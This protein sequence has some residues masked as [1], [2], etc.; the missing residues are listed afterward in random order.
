[1]FVVGCKLEIPSK[2]PGTRMQRNNAVGK[3]VVAG[4]F[5]TGERWGGITDP[6]VKKIKRRVITSRNPRWTATAFPSFVL[7]RLMTSFAWPGN[8]IEPPFLLAS[9]GIVGGKKAANAKFAA[10]YP[11]DD[12]MVHDKR[13]SSKRKSIGWLR[14]SSLPIYFPRV[15]FN[16]N[17]I[18]VQTAKKE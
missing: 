9:R 1:M 6:P 18:S 11:D 13:R 4:A 8:G 2:L 5:I 17:Q 12:G 15:R 7:P 16:G 3:K 10:R 14:H